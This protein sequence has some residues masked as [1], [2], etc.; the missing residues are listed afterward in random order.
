MAGQHRPVQAE[1]ADRV[2]Q[3]GEMLVEAVRARERGT[4]ATAAQ[5]NGVEVQS[6]GSVLATACQQ[7]ALA[8]MPCTAS[9]GRGPWPQDST[10]SVPPATSAS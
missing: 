2:A 9:T 7:V 1:C 4:V 3:V 8:V 6:S 10:R 5:V